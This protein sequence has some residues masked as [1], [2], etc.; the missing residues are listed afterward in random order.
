MTGR[1]S[2]A[3]TPVVHVVFVTHFDATPITSSVLCF[4]HDSDMAIDAIDEFS[5][6][7]FDQLTDTQYGELALKDDRPL[8][9]REM[10]WN[11]LFPSDDTSDIVQVFERNSETGRVSAR[12]VRRIETSPVSGFEF[13]LSDSAQTALYIVSI[14]DYDDENTHGRVTPLCFTNDTEAGMEAL[15]HHTRQVYSQLSGA[16][17]AAAADALDDD[18]PLRDRE[19]G[20]HVRFIDPELVNMKQETF[21]VLFIRVHE[22]DDGKRRN[23]V[24]RARRIHLQ[25]TSL[26][27]DAYLKR[28]S[29]WDCFF[30]EAPQLTCDATFNDD[31]A[32]SGHDVEADADVDFE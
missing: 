26:F 23:K 14:I 3:R 6:T 15:E 4:V 20:W 24:H 31:A 13:A 10:G 30:M 12:C 1:G 5:V 19:P 18:R 16:D 25:P 32:A 21:D 28:P 2:G 11:I 17:D 22:L 29:Q 9:E 27:I 7:L 8:D